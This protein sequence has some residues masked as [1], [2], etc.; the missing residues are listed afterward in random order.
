M[1]FSLAFLVADAGPWLVAGAGFVDAAGASVA[2]S[3][4]NLDKQN[5]TSVEDTV[6]DLN[7]LCAQAR[8]A[9]HAGEQMQDLSQNLVKEGPE[10]AKATQAQLRGI[11]TQMQQKQASIDQ[12]KAER[13]GQLLAVVLG[14]AVVTGVFLFFALAKGRQMRANLDV[15]RK[16]EASAA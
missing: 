7:S 5:K 4:F 12:W 8:W 16:L 9:R 3:N 11:R 13:G 14:C 10:L 1:L 2:T 15:L 6:K